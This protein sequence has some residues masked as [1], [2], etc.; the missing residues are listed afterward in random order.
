M[1][2][3]LHLGWQYTTP[4]LDP[5]PPPRRPTPP[6]QERI[7]PGWLAAQRREQNLLSR[8]LRAACAAC[9]VLAAVLIVAVLA[10][11]LNALA[12][13]GAAVAA[14]LA[15]VSGR[16]IRRGERA[17]RSRIDAEQRR[18]S[19]IRAR[20][21]GRLF[22]WQEEHAAR[23]RAWQ[24]HRLAYDQQKRWYAVT[25]PPGVHR[26]EVVGGTLP[27]WSALLT[28]ASA[29]LLAEGGQVTVLDLTDSAVALD[30]IAFAGSGTGV[31]VLPEDLH[32]LDPGLGL[33]P[34]GFRLSGH[35]LADVLAL[36]VNTTDDHGTT[37]DLSH[38]R[39]IL[40]Q[41]IGILGDDATIASVAAAL[42]TL[43]QIGNP[44][45]DVNASLINAAQVDQIRSAF[46]TGAVN[47]VVI[48]RAWTLES[49]LRTLGSLGTGLVDA[50]HDA[51]L[52]VLALSRSAGALDGKVLAAYLAISLTHVLRQAERGGGWR[53]TVFVL[54]AD[55]LRADVLDRLS[56]GCERTDTGL[57]LAYRMLS[58]PVRQ[59][60]GRGD[61]AIGFMRLG[62]A[63]E[64]RAASEQIGTEHRFMLSQLTA[65]IGESVTDTTT[66]SYTST[67][68]ST[69]SV[70]SSR[71]A[72]VSTS[73]GTSHSG[74]GGSGVLPLAGA[75][76]SRGVQ[77]TDSRTSGLAE[78]VSEGLS[79]STAWGRSTS[80]AAGSSESVAYAAQR[81]REF[82]VEQ[83]ELQ[84]LPASA[85]ILSYAGQAGREL[86]LAD[87]NPGIASLRSATMDTLD[88]A[89]SASTGPESAG[90]ASAGPVSTE[91]V[92]AEPVAAGPPVRR[93]TVE[94]PNLGPPPPRL[95][96][97]R[98]RRNSR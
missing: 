50:E 52:R 31:R 34:G 22:A 93:F 77:A 14:L 54:G 75:T 29:Y 76:S 95:D 2:S 24:A 97:R 91:P 89:L 78:S 49:Q 96:W 88:A 21:E 10:G 16:A 19:E 57:V 55:R 37:R 8:P 13:A 59:R 17:L 62:N 41:V 26:V 79:L 39:A 11:W 83:H 42:R 27:G 15:L 23:V 5:G 60:L 56:D 69:G 1:T 20:T 25:V 80:T 4:V 7:N 66:G 84:R 65:T 53:H 85:L 30:L 9:V 67:A 36:T 47:R 51:R 86:V 46:G 90:P 45:D 3:Q 6:D 87:V 74:S 82:L 70:T 40:E 71:S 72:S 81:S 12:A 58:A 61:A 32:L 94:P 98:S 18:V 68:G 63:E 44:A 64:A 92:A 28:T 38:D 43:A 35:A 33:M 48:E 73:S